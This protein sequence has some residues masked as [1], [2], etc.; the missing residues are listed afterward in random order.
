MTKPF[1]V[2]QRV[3][4]HYV[5]CDDKE[6]VYPGRLLSFN[7]THAAV[8]LDALGVVVAEIDAIAHSKKME[9]AA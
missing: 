1:E 6:H 9:R 8:Q 3:V 5:D 7:R 4:V 2:N